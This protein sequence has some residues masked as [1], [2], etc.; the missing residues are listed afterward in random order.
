M[1]VCMLTTADA[2]VLHRVADGVFDGPVVPALAAEFL[3]D[4]RHLICVAIEDGVVVGFASA[5]RYVPPDKPSA[6]WINEVGVSPRFQRRGVGKA[7]KSHLLAEAETRGCR[8]A[9][10]L[11]HEGYTA[12][13]ALLS[14][15]GGSERQAGLMVAFTLTK[16]LAVERAR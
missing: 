9:W 15:A 7:I 3:A 2:A 12:A 8:E 10:V 1:D 13:R 14:S 4:D 11:T 6:M 5:V 16:Q